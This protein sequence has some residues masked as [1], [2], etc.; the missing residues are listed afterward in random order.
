[1]EL[2]EHNVTIG[3]AVK[4]SREQRNMTQVELAAKSNISRQTINNI[5]SGRITT[6]IDTLAALSSALGISLG[7]FLGLNVVEHTAG[8][9]K[10]QI[11][12]FLKKKK[13]Q[14]N[15]DTFNS[16]SVLLDQIFV[17]RILSYKETETLEIEWKSGFR[18]RYPIVKN[19]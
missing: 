16:L 8:L 3:K 5:E 14:L 9:T 17:V 18:S 10:V 19:N 15:A 6:T 11:K 1:M 2:K 7:L 4:S 12:E 13:D